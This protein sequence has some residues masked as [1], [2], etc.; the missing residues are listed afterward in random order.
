CRQSRS[1]FAPSTRCCRVD[2][3]WNAPSSRLPRCRSKS[4][5]SGG[6]SPSGFVPIRRFRL[7]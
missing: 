3:P 4:V 7:C 5:S 2:V 1:G 6:C